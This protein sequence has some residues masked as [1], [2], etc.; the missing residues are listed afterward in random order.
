M[1]QRLFLVRW[2]YFNGSMADLSVY[3]NQLP[4]VGTVAAQYAAETHPAAELTSVTSPAGRT[5]LSATYDTVNDR[6]ATVT[7]ADGGTWT[8]G[9]AVASSSSAAYDSAVLAISPEDFWPLSD[10]A[11]PLAADMVGSAATAASPRPPATYANVTL[12]AA[13]PDRVRGRDRGQL[14]RH[15]LAGQHPRRVL[16]RHRRGVGRAV[17]QDHRARDPAVLRG[18]GPTAS[19]CRC[20]SRREQLP[21]GD[22]RQH[23]R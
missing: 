2:S 23:A 12:G 7:D 19:R 13:G 1:R 3:Q 8:Y 22:S 11:G 4:S 5:E 14:H 17:V 18:P 15:Q 16:H 21:G 10:T 9:G 20:G 6:V